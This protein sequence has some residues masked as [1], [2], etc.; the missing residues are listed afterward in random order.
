[1]KRPSLSSLNSSPNHSALASCLNKCLKAKA[2]KPGKQIHAVLLTAGID[3]EVLSLDSK[4][5]GLYA[6]CGDVRSAKLVFGKVQRP[7]VFALN[8]MVLASAFVG[9]YQGAVGYF[10][11]MQELG[12]GCNKFTFSVVL[13]ACLGMMD[14]NKGK[15][16]HAMVYKMGYANDVSV[17]NAMIDMYCKC[18]S[19][20][21]A[22][23]VFDGMAGR[24]V[25]SWT[26]M[27]CGYC[28]VGKTE[29]ALVLFERMK[30]RGL[31]PNDFTW[32]A[33]ITGFARCGDRNG[34]Y[35]LFSRMTRAGLV[36]DLIT[37]NAII[38][39]FAQSQ[40][41]GEALKS[42]RDMLV[43]GT[44]PNHVT[45]TGLLPACGLIGSIKRGR[46]IHC[47][48]YRMELDRNVFVACA[49]IDMYSKCGNMKNARSVFDMAPVKNVVLWNAMIGCYG[50]HGMVDSSLQL[51][52]TMQEE[53]VQASEVT[54]ICVLSAC[55]HSGAV[56]RGIR[57][58]R[59]MEE[60]YGVKAS[61]EHYACVVDL[62]CRSGKMV[63]AYEVVKGM[64]IEI[65]ESIIG[66]FFNGCKVNGRQDLAKML[67]ED[68]MRMDL[69]NP[70]GLVT[71]SNIYAA[72]GD[73]EEVLDVRKA[74]KKKKIYKKHGSS[75]L[76]K[77][78]E[79]VGVNTKKEGNILDFEQRASVL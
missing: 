69:K 47:L 62:L 64:P 3:T 56:E 20:C 39:G 79:F 67:A 77:M 60:C 53:G 65:T 55:S 44:K 45:I 63:E 16:V 28:N 66:A 59:S 72:H 73:W 42:F 14:A 15:E 10:S 38:S 61:K 22:R 40:H 78:D 51:F 70:G 21:C 48:I 13:K 29:Q 35:A 43:S 68:I 71:L 19:V 27:I 54:L 41:A 74:M 58:F 33:I 25:T 76:E 6:S 52:K 17:A 2:L 57:I 18:G 46:E 23:R 37:W 5:V 9:N 34:V 31:E 12:I 7:N 1:M 8:W 36:P 26:C 75:W 32:N 11:L 49:L 24:D 50:K 30:L 4:L